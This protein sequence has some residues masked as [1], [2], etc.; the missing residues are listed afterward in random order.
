MLSFVSIDF[1]IDTHAHSH[2][3]IYN[4][5]VQYYSFIDTQYMQL[6]D[7]IHHHFNRIHVTVNP[8]K[9]CTSEQKKKQQSRIDAEEEKEREREMRKTKEKARLIWNWIHF[10]GTSFILWAIWVI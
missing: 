1:D 2:Q 4:T 5:V 7:N 10:E 3:F 8:F 6:C 9:M